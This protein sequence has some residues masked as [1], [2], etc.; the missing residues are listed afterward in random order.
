MEEENL[1]ET[2]ETDENEETDEHTIDDI[3]EKLEEVID[4]L[5]KQL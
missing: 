2:E 5:T 1:Q 4:I 3:Y